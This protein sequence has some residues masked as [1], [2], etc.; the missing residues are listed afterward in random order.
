MTF[1][2]EV[3]ALQK[4]EKVVDA[5][6]RA[7]IPKIQDSTISHDDWDE[8]RQRGFKGYS[9]K[10]FSTDANE[11][12]LQLEIYAGCGEYDSAYLTLPYEALDD[13]E[14]WIKQKETQQTE[15]RQAKANAEKAEEEKREAERIERERVEYL[16]LK[17][18]FEV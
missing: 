11:I 3:I 14:T 16:R 10:E 7:A 6:I 9:Y 5:R 8:D 4:A 13:I 17:E 15:K 1:R 2:E 18:K 12:T